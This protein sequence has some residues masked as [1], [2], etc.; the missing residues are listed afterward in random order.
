M[1]WLDIRDRS[2]RSYD[3]D[4]T[5]SR[6]LNFDSHLFLISKIHDALVLDAL[7]N[8]FDCPKQDGCATHEGDDFGCRASKALLG[9]LPG[10]MPPDG[11]RIKQADDFGVAR[12]YEVDMEFRTVCH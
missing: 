3:D 9:Y 4:K 8:P 11:R 1:V 10:V 2:I 5:I 6:L 7:S 12:R